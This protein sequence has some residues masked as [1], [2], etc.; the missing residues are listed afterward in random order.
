MGDR[1]VQMLLDVVVPGD[2][3]PMLYLAELIQDVNVLLHR[4]GV[5]ESVWAVRLPEDRR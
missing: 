4:K 3:E 2:Q 5:Q 1:H